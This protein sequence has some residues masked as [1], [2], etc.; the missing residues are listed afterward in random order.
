[1]TRDTAGTNGDSQP[2]TVLHCSWLHW[3]ACRHDKRKTLSYHALV[4]IFP[5]PHPRQKKLEPNPAFPSDTPHL[6]EDVPCRSRF[7]SIRRD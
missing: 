4:R 5:A 6:M 2:H 3:K 7:T 1:M